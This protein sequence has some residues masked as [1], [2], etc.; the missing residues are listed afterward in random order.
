MKK[1]KSFKDVKKK[2]NKKKEDSSTDREMRWTSAPPKEVVD[3]Y[4]NGIK[5]GKIKIKRN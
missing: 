5:S 2:V 4:V 1:V 3:K